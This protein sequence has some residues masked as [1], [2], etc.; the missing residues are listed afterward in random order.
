MIVKYF[1]IN[2]IKDLNNKLILLYGKNEGLKTQAIQQ[3]LSKEIRPLNYEE[4]EIIEGSSEFIESILNKSLFDS[5]KTIV[6]KRATDKIIKILDKIK[7]KNIEDTIII[8]SENLDKKSKLRT[9]F[10]KEKNYICVPFYPDNEQTLLKFAQNFLREK[11]ISVSTSNINILVSKCNGERENLSNELNKIEFYSK[12]GREI[13]SEVI[14]KLSNL[15]ENHN[16]SV[17]I[18]NCLIKNE[19]KTIK[20]LNENSFSNEDCILIIRTFISKS[21]KLLNLSKEFENNQNIDQT[22]SSAKP[23]IFWKDKEITKK[24]I[25][26]WNS[27]SVKRLIYMLTEIELQIKKNYNNPI[28]LITDFILN[29]I[30]I[31][32]SN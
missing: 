15:T 10:E 28:N 19:K 8:C 16:I 21:K 24:Q 11:N 18:D 2:K 22:L 4:K 17:L 1:E 5:K 23:P 7:D 6:I 30:K 3:I 20:I 25:I 31:K 14:L 29:Q 12:N 9:L 26:L 13:T 32:A 27:Q